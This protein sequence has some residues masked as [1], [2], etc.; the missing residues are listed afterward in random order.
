MDL[1]DYVKHKW[2]TWFLSLRIIP[3]AKKTMIAWLMWDW[4]LKLRIK[5]IPENWKANKE[6]IL[7]ISKELWVKKSQVEIVS[8][9][10][11]QNKL[12]KIDF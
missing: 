4:N 7:F 11:S 1:I 9:N 2:N 6:L 10:S 8:G 5:S 12:V 3:N